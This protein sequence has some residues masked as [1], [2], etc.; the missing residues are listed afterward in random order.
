MNF[1]RKK[2]RRSQLGSCN[3]PAI[4]TCFRQFC[5]FALTIVVLLPA[6]SK[7]MFASETNSV[8]SLD[9]LRTLTPQATA[10]PLRL[11]GVVVCYDAGWHQLYLDDGS[12]T[13]YF[14]ADNFSV[15][16]EKGQWVEI[17]GIVAT[18][19]SLMNLNL[20]ILGPTNL[21]PAKPMK[22][23]ELAAEHGQWVQISGRVMSAEASRGRLALLL[24]ANGENCLVYVLAS[25]P[26]VDFTN[27]LNCE[28]RVRG[29]N[30]S[31]TV[32]GQLDS[33]IL[34]A[35]GMD[36]VKVTQPATP[37]SPIPV[38]SI[39]SLFNREL[40]AWTNRWVHING[41][42]ASYQPG[43]WLVLKDAT[44][45]I[46]A[47]IIQQT[48]AAED[49][50]AD[51]W[52]FLEVSK[53]E[54][55]L[56]NAYFEAAGPPPDNAEQIASASQTSKPVE[57]P[58]VIQRMS[59]IRKLRHQ[60]AAKNIPVQ[61]RGVLTFA[62][63]AWRNGF[64]QNKGDALYVDLEPSQTDLRAG[65]WVELR[66]QTSPGGF[67]PEVIHCSIK[68]LGTTNLPTPMRVNIEDLVNGEWDAHW[69]EMEGVIR[70][71]EQRSDHIYLSV[72]TSGGRFR[73]IIPQSDDKP[74]PDQLIDA[75]VR[76]QGACTSE[77]NT[78]QQLSGITLHTPS[79]DLVKVLEFPPTDP[80][81]IETTRLDSVATFDP[82]RLAGRRIKV[83]GVVTLDLPGQGFYLQDDSGGM[84]VLT[85]LTNAIHIGDLVEGLGFP[86]IRDFS[87]SLEEATFRKV[88]SQN[89]AP[90]K[91]TTAEQILLSGS[92]DAQ[93]VKIRAR[94]LQNVPRSAH[95][96]LVLQDGPVIFTANVES[97]KEGNNLPALESGSRLAVTGICSIQGGE[98]H[99]PVTFR[100]LVPGVSDIEVLETPPWWTSRYTLMLAGGL[101]LAVSVAL[102]W[103]GLL[104]RQVRLQTEVIRQKL[105]EEEAL[106]QEILEISTRE[107]RRIGHDLHDGV[108]Q[109]LAGIALL[110]STLADDLA[111]KG[112]TD[113][114]T[115]ERI[116][117]LLNGAI[118]QTRGV[119]R[120]LFPVR[121]EEKGL[122]FALEE[123]AGNA[124]ELFKV[125]CQFVAE[126]P[127]ANLPNNTA[128]HLYYIALEAVANAAKHAAPKNIYITLTGAVE[129]CSLCVQDDGIGFN[130]AGS[131][132]TG[133]GLRI[134]QYRARV[135]G[136]TLN[137][138]SQPG[139]GTKVAC[140]FTP[141]PGGSSPPG[142]TPDKPRA[143]TRIEPIS[144]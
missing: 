16:P 112:S 124:S 135:I 140:V 72:M 98:Q 37:Q 2:A 33:A 131:T 38:V 13:E 111:E 31:K 129:R 26:S 69:I 87:P 116:S 92:S 82:D 66:G 96:Q 21:P 30:A 128:L 108:C 64:L 143:G 18:N 63:P 101:L 65:Q 85:R 55:I 77:L 60:D 52:G 139:S 71:V 34:F 29:I 50:R 28:V 122:V 58:K 115:A 120:G 15:Q 20:T 103:V 86:A 110:T 99:E 73:V 35:P 1:F 78:R 12:D 45:T 83:R 132:H 46:R 125:N 121:L 67:A 137:L 11:H 138:Q 89:L 104:R 7:E 43:Q 44:G 117:N 70:R 59:D 76:I 32:D 107:Q 130:H 23:S 142:E 17:T 93:M 100:L 48:E 118:D 95:P 27:L 19:N 113:A 8:V 90:A 88:G 126:N 53:D 106:E 114:V 144:T 136:A 127:P 109:Q 49:G 4:L 36:E 81:S 102:A 42:I 94:L 84:Q 97:Q 74:A 54:T 134:M 141:A 39:S 51:V 9:Q 10:R 123:L 6:L 5:V 68:V 14:D 62:D 80:F 41:L 91:Q 79:L 57:L 22:L 75:L 25:A 105:K 3:G 40:A 119:A 61:V 56:R 24:H 47:R 133:M